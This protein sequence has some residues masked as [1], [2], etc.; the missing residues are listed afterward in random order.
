[1]F[2]YLKLLVFSC[3]YLDLFLLRARGKDFQT[4]SLPSMKSVQYPGLL[5]IYY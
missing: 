2:F 3:L 4:L 5:L 1:M